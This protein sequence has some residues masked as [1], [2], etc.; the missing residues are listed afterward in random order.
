MTR[1]L[2]SFTASPIRRA[3]CVT[4]SRKYLEL[5]DWQLVRKAAID[6]DLL[7]LHSESSRKRVSGELIKRL[8]NLGPKELAK[9][10][11]AQTTT[12]AQFAILWVA[13]CRTYEFVSDFT[14]QVVAERWGTGRGTLPYGAYEEFCSEAALVHPEL[15]KLAEGTKGRL[16]NQLYQMLREMGFIDESLNLN[17]YLLPA[18]CS[19]LVAPADLR[20]FPTAAKEG[21]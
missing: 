4:L 7:M 5:N 12:P 14:Q 17:P 3:E 9:L 20:F 13:V 2:L 10:A 16:R 11:D 21:V 1:Y 6:E 19:G 8:K 15:A 18:E